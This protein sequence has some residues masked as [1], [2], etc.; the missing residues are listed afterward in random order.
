MRGFNE[1]IRKK[2]DKI[3]H[4]DSVRMKHGVLI[5]QDDYEA[6]DINNNLRY[7]D[8]RGGAIAC[9]HLSFEWL[10]RHKRKLPRT[11]HA[12]E[13][14]RDDPKA[15]H[16]K[17]R[18]YDGVISIAT[19]RDNKY[20]NHQIQTKANQYIAVDSESNGLGLALHYLAK[21]ME[22]GE[23]R[24]MTIG[25]IDHLMA[26][27]IERKVEP[28]RYIIK[29]YDPNK[30]VVHIRA[31]CKNLDAVS[32]LAF[33]DFLTP[34]QMG[35]YFTT[36]K[37]AM[38]SVYDDPTCSEKPAE[39]RNM[40]VFMLDLDGDEE[41]I[42]KKNA[43][44]YAMS[45]FD[46]RI[47]S[48]SYLERLLER[49]D[50]P[51]SVDDMVL[52]ESKTREGCTPLNSCFRFGWTEVIE[53]LVD[54]ILECDKL[55]GEQKIKLLRC[56]IDGNSG[57]IEACICNYAKTIESFVSKITQTDRLNEREKMLLLNQRTV[58]DEYPLAAVV[59]CG[60]R[61]GFDGI[62]AAY[63]CV[64]TV[65]EEDTVINHIEAF[66]D[67]L[68]ERFPK[69]AKVG[70]FKSKHFSSVDSFIK[71]VR[72][73]I[74]KAK[75]DHFTPDIHK[76]L[77]EKFANKL[78]D[79]WRVLGDPENIGRSYQVLQDCFEKHVLLAPI[80]NSDDYSPAMSAYG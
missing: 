35:C 37:L 16:K 10:R 65:K 61:E 36:N 74:A 46:G 2:L 63:M 1:Y 60:N 19:L 38:L 31:I 50:D 32:S 17:Y 18:D 39:V 6:R 23:T 73:E 64:D 40:E 54:T 58:T 7:G 20:D 8:Y 66:V 59:L 72:L 75:R 11:E 24:L 70:F 45:A 21:S 48:A 14:R 25:S 76:K 69:K 3:S 13:P 49:C 41:K 5:Y 78:F 42:K 62:M 34:A 80:R 47:E 22:A 56:E 15:Y 28:D 79:L 44:L 12:D 52:L 4:R 55:T 53:C 27:A 77:C 43:D 30:T 71:M 9:R 51:V 26:I 33:S 57:L 67:E 68:S 29:Y